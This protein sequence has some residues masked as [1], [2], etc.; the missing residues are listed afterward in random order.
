M[1]KMFSMNRDFFI[2][3]ICLVTTFTLFTSLS[4]KLGVS[5]LAANTIL[6]QMHLIFAYIF[7]GLANASSILIGN[8]KG[9][10][11]LA[12]YQQTMKLSFHWNLGI[13]IGLG[14]FFVLFDEKLLQYFTN[15]DEVLA[16]AIDYSIWIAIYPLVGFWGLILNGVF[17]GATDFAPIRNSL[18][19]ALLIF[20]IATWLFIMVSI[21]FIFSR[22]FCFL[23]DVYRKTKTYFY[24]VIVL[25]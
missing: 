14:L 2:R 15:I 24:R 7:D 19:Y 5:V 3:T 6:F 20:L 9:K 4:S 12:L 13:S 23:R 16:L 18:V 17:T 11:D 1:K 21:Y 8:A 22:P 25:D 10:K